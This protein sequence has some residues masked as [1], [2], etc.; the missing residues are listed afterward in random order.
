MSHV[1]E[2]APSLEVI[3]PAE[4]TALLSADCYDPFSILGLHVRDG[5]VYV[6][7]FF[8][9]ADRVTLIDAADG[10]SVCEVPRCHN[11]GIFAAVVPGRTEW[12]HYRLAVSWGTNRYVLEDPY[13]FPPVI[14]AI[15]E[16]LFSEGNHF[17][18]YEKLGSHPMMLEG[19]S[20]VHF[21]VWAPNARRVSVVGNF[22]GW[23]G[24]RHMM[25]ARGAS[26]IFEIFIPDLGLNE[27]Y[28]YE[29]KAQDGTIMPLKA[30]PV[31]F[32]AE[33]PPRTASLTSQVGDTKWHDEDWLSVR[34][35]RHATNAPIAIYEVHAGSWRKVDGWRRLTY[36]ELA[37]A[38]VPYVK[39]MG[40]TH[41]ELMP[42]H[43][44]PFDGSWGYQPVGLFA[45]TSRFGT[46]DDFKYLVDTCHQAGLGLII[47]WVPGHFPTDAHGLAHFDGTALYEHL[48]PRKGYHP[49]WNT[50]IYNYGRPEVSNFLI[51]NA[52][53]W[54]KRFHVDALRVDAVASMIYL[55]YSRKEGEWEPNI[56]GGNENL[57]AI[58]FLKR[59]N[60]VVYGNVEGITMVAEE[61][62]AWPAVSRPTDVGGLGFGYKWNMGWMNDTL[63]YISREPVHRRYHH[64]QMTF[65][66]V[67]AF[68]ENFILPI[69]HD[70]VVHGKGSLLGRIPGD[71]WQQFATL[72]AYYGFM[73]GHPGKKLLFMGCEFAQGREWNHE[74]ELDWF[75]L[76]YPQHQGVQRLVKDLNR[77][78]R[79]HPT[80][81]ATDTDSRGFEWIEANADAESYYSFLRRGDGSTP[82]IAVA[83][84]FTPVPREG[85]RI[86]LP[87]KGTWRE[88]L[89]TDS[90]L[91][92][93]SGV[94]NQGA[95]IAEDIPWND[96]PYSASVTLPPL[97]T[98]MFEY[99][100]G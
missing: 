9:G 35:E 85:V 68:S 60:E 5:H 51:A 99:A 40:F 48:D 10:A 50:L 46:P 23:D 1:S 70:E 94:G 30:D 61:S 42:V 21:A 79:D 41:I 95:V 29:I 90:T 63:D 13:R 14:G 43:E 53:F 72:R 98:V 49:D 58:A 19:I 44:F 86:G 66:M 57:E 75:L 73:W 4:I 77:L 56:Y 31:G 2:I 96:R 34:G 15:D 27:A 62:T 81:Y 88:I 59:L 93:G 22:N 47:D 45:P 78:Y 38:L 7:A 16:H 97:A 89:N 28:K 84:N 8:P 11:D 20:G 74:G 3:S 80:L 100:D 91:Y 65:G 17:E 82:P 25:R 24:R 83:C 37:D 18:L 39:D 12:F 52:L 69:S 71:G 6:R 67:Y 92:D 26:G 54:M 87:H 36:R 32:H 64:H 76:D 33:V 55:D